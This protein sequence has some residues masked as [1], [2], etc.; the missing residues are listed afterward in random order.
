MGPFRQ[1][2]RKIGPFIYFLLKK[3]GGGAIIYLAVLKK[4][5][6]RRSH[7]YYVIYR[8][9]HPHPPAQLARII[10]LIFWKKNKNDNLHELSFSGKI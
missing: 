1:E 2:S 3:R 4:G 6:I 8:K 10:K 7:P 9:L 5:A